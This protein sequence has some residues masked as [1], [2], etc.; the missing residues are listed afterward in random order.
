MITLQIY[1]YR[2]FLFPG[3]LSAA[4]IYVQKQS[5]VTVWSVTFALDAV[6]ATLQGVHVLIWRATFQDPPDTTMEGARMDDERFWLQIL[7]KH[8]CNASTRTLFWTLA[9]GC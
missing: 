3:Q 8:H 5:L 2:S 4:A 9:A 7:Q 1:K 6:H